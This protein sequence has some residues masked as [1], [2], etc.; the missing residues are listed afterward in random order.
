M[1]IL[2]IIYAVVLVVLA[3][4]FTVVGIQLILV[5]WQVRKTVVK[6]NTAVDTF[7]IKFAQVAQPLQQL[8][9]L[10]AGLK[11][12]MKVFDAFTTWLNREK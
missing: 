7:Q 1:E 3:I 5:L 9:G 10:A 2:P 12:G 8:G 6:I 4:V 11:T